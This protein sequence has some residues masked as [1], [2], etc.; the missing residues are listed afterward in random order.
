MFSSCCFFSS[1][2]AKKVCDLMINICPL[3]FLFCLCSFLTSLFWNLFLWFWWLLYLLQ[4]LSL[5]MT[6][7]IELLQKQSILFFLVAVHELS[8][9]KHGFCCF[10]QQKMAWYLILINRVHKYHH[11]T[12]F[13]VVKCYVDQYSWFA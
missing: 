10:L 3:M 6:N 9:C 5:I 11:G 8:F 7:E 13:A 2:F 12:E 4:V 1:F